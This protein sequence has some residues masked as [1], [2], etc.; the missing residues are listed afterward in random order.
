MMSKNILITGASGTFGQLFVRELLKN[1]HTVVASMRNTKTTNRTIAESLSTLG[2][3]VVELDVSDE[4]SVKCGVDLALAHLGT[5]DVVINN[6]G[7]G[8]YGLQEAFTTEDWHAIFDVNVFGVERVNRAVLP[9][10]RQ[11]KSGLLIHISSLIGRMVL[12]FWGAYSASK[13]ALEAMTENYRV[14][15]SEFGIDV[16]LIEPGPY[17]T[18]FFVST[19]SASDRKREESYGELFESSKVSFDDFGKLLA[20]N[21]EQNPQ[22]VADA[23]ANIID[24]AKGKRAFRTVVD[25][26]GIGSEIEKLNNVQEEI[27]K[28]V[29][30][31]FGIGEML[32]LKLI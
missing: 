27:N 4:E 6:A 12:P 15:L 11:N 21:K 17:A 22:N 24:T 1:N 9:H 14:E 3:Y 7:L 23:I 26:I 8:A 20:S 30:G 18:E 25:S 5:L 32:E 2:A 10:M 28:N 19:L 29:Y 31:S 16:C 13:W